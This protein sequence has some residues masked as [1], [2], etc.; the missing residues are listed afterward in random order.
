MQMQDLFSSWVK[1]CVLCTAVR[2]D[3]KRMI[4]WLL[5]IIVQAEEDAAAK[6]RSAKYFCQK[7]WEI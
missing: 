2:H 7:T 1:L 3:G 5:L 4:S 6:T